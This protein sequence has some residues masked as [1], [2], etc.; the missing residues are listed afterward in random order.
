MLTCLSGYLLLKIVYCQVDDSLLTDLESS[1]EPDF[2][3]DL[4][5]DIQTR[6]S[7]SLNTPAIV[8]YT[9]SNA[10]RSPVTFTCHACTNCHSKVYFTT[11][12]CP[13]GIEMCYV[14]MLLLS[15]VRIGHVFSLDCL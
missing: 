4:A 14:S 10:Q 6:S 1:N 12:I 5:V 7:L 8:S 3:V 11:D 15:S 13:S 9:V 2:Q